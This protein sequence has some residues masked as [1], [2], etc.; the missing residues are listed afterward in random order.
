[1]P[2]QIANIDLFFFAHNTLIH[3]SRD[4]FWLDSGQNPAKSRGEALEK[5]SINVVRIEIGQFYWRILEHE[6]LS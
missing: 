4:I 1:M 5:P 3:A 2:D 6:F